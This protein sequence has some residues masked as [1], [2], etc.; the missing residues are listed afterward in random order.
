MVVFLLF[1]ATR[2]EVYQVCSCLKYMSKMTY[3][4]VLCFL[5]VSL[6]DLSIKKNE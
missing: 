6:S 2:Q 4:Q 5:Q 3:M 1:H